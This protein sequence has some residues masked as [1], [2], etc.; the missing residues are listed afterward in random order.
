[1]VEKI[2][3]VAQVAPAK[4]NPISLFSNGL[5][6]LCESRYRLV[7]RPS[8]PCELNT[9]SPKCLYERPSSVWEK[10]GLLFPGKSF[11]HLTVQ[12]DHSQAWWPWIFSKILSTPFSFFQPMSSQPSVV[13]SGQFPTSTQPMNSVW[14]RETSER[15]PLNGRTQ[16]SL[17]GSNHVSRNLVTTTFSILLTDT[18]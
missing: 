9:Q 3:C 13:V 15:P 8:T 16:L 12:R 6:W 2:N 14:C 7:P 11:Q 1:M 17:W 4:F 18:S 10:K 5:R